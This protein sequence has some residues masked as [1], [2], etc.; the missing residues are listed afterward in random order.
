MLITGGNKGVGKGIALA[1][2]KA[3]ADIIIHY[4]SDKTSAESVCGTIQS[5]GCR[6]EIIQCDF[7]N[8]LDINKFIEK[9]I[10]IF[11][12]ID[13][14][15]NCAAAYKSCAFLK[16][17]AEEFSWMH[18][19]NALAPMRL[20][21]EF[22]QYCI[23]SQRSGSIVN[24]SSISGS[25]PSSNSTL[26]SCSKAS[27][28]MLTRCAALELSE[29]NIR[30]NAIMP[31]LIDTE[32]NHDFKT[33]DQEGWQKAINEIPLRKAG[34]PFDCG[35]MAVFLASEKAKWITGAVIPIDGGMTISWRS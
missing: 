14:L 10:E 2:A 32:S 25:M 31:G 15:I 24:V 17:T 4:H 26:N 13:S 1:C 21:Q 22:A 9:A 12:H 29:Y 16:L 27:L 28:N 34:E 11:G 8:E 33:K 3:G 18:Q 30:V 19:V 6:T 20:T 23:S 35:E 5:M 7:T